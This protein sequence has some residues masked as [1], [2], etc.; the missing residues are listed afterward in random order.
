MPGKKYIPERLSGLCHSE[1]ELPEQRPG[2]FR[3]KNA[4]V[5]I[6]NRLGGVMVSVLANGRTVFCLTSG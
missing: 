3:R 6:E 5:Y 4:L 2:A 1:K